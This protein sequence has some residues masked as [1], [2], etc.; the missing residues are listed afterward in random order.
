[1]DKVEL[2]TN[3]AQVLDE[4]SKSIAR[5]NMGLGSAS[6]KGVATTLS[7]SD[8]L[9]TANAVKSAIDEIK[10]NQIPMQNII[11]VNPSAVVDVTG[12]TYRTFKSAMAYI[13]SK[14]PTSENRWEIVLSSGTL[15]QTGTTYTLTYNSESI[16]LDENDVIILP[17]IY[18]VGNRTIINSYIFS[19]TFI[20]SVSYRDIPTSSVIENCII[21][22][23]DLSYSSSSGINA[24]SATRCTFQGLTNLTYRK[25][26]STYE[27]GI[28]TFD[29]FI[30]DCDLTNGSTSGVLN[31]MNAFFISVNSCFLGGTMPSCFV[32]DNTSYPLFKSIN[33]TLTGITLYGGELANCYIRSSSSDSF[34]YYSVFNQGCSYEITNC[35]FSDAKIL[36]NNVQSSSQVVFRH[37]TLCSNSFI[38]LRLS[39][40]RVLCQNC[41]FDGCHIWK[42]S[43]LGASIS[44][45]N[46]V[47]CAGYLNTLV[48]SSYDITDPLGNASSTYSLLSDEN[49][50]NMGAIYKNTISG[51]LATEVQEA[52]DELASTKVSKETGKILSSND[53]TDDEK[54]KLAGI[55]SGAEVNVQ[56]DWNATSGDALILNKPTLGTSSSKNY[57]ASIT[58]DTSTIPLTSAVYAALLLKQDALSVT[59]PLVL[60][61][62]TLSVSNATTTS[63]GVVEIGSNLSIADGVLSAPVATSSSNG[64]M[65]LYSS[66]GENTNG[67]MTQKSIFDALALKQNNITS[68]SS[69]LTITNSVISI[70]NATASSYGVVKI[71]TGL[72]VDS[73]GYL[74]STHI[75]Y[76]AGSGI[77]LDSSIISLLTASTTILGGVKVDGTSITISNGVISSIY[78]LPIAT[79]TLGGVKNGGNVVVSADGTMNY[80]L[81]TA[82]TSVLGGVKVGSNLS[83]AD[84]VLSG[85]PDTTYTVDTAKGLTLSGTLISINY[86]TKTSYGVVEVGDNISVSNGVISI[87]VATSSTLGLIKIG[88]GLDIVNG[89]VS[90]SIP[91]AS[92]S[93]LGLIKVGYTSSDKNYA[94]VLDSSSKAYVNVPWTDTTYTLP[95][96]SSTVLGGIKVGTNLSIDESG[97]LSAAT[98][99]Y[100]LPTASTTTLGGVK[101][102]GTTVLISSE[103]VISAVSSGGSVYQAGVGLTFNTST[104]PITINANYASATVFGVIKV[105]S[106]LSVT[107]GVLSASAP[108]VYT[109]GDGLS[110]TDG[111][112]ALNVASASTFGGTRIDGVSIV[113]SNGVISVGSATTSTIGGIIVGNGLN[114]SNSVLSVAQIVAGD[115]LG[116]VKNGGN[117]VIDSS[118]KMNY[119]LPTAS[120]SVLGGVKV[121]SNLSI[122]DGVLSASASNVYTAG[123]G[124]SLNDLEFSLAYATSS[125]IGGIIVGS[126]LSISDGILNYTLPTSS[127][128]TLGG[129]KVDGTSITISN[130]VISSVYTLPTA[131]TTLLGGVKIDG[132]SIT[133]SNGIISALTYTLP[134]ASTTTSGGIIVGSGLSISS[135]VLSVTALNATNPIN[136]NSSTN[137]LSLLYSTDYF[138]LN[139][140]NQLVGTNSFSSFVIVG[141][142][143]T[144]LRSTNA[145][146]SFS[147]IQGTGVTFTANDST[148]PK[149]LTIDLA[150]ATS[151]TIGGVKLYKETNAESW[152]TYPDDG[153]FTPSA[154]NY[155]VTNNSSYVS[156]SLT[157]GGSTTVT[158]IRNLIVANNSSMI[159]LGNGTTTYGTLA[160]YESTSTGSTDVLTQTGSTVSW[161]PDISVK[162]DYSATYQAKSIKIVTAIPDTVTANTLYVLMEA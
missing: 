10:I 146:T 2:L 123:L 127:T 108:N 58:N 70:A 134:A 81:P 96:A 128:T 67:T 143:T 27:C 12:A 141:S 43:S 63:F 161:V 87:P 136:Y 139:E 107:D 132:T 23:I 37:C 77:S 121:G 57:S 145:T 46:Y 104:S 8:D 13:L 110:L 33:S 135:G 54:S 112:F 15:D 156:Y 51:L 64:V 44:L 98:G 152:V 61:S 53:Y 71:G 91:T 85:T 133:I 19:R 29:S 103:G 137:T 130:G 9:I 157:S 35:S 131:S 52:L 80:T 4:D 86:S 120:T 30:I 76:V 95:V 39:E 32:K 7:D 90:T 14:S 38:F 11:Y 100:T 115:S 6:V 111:S 40:S 21:T 34:N 60:S 49:I 125:V 78:N 122:T 22:H 66:S 114:I 162:Y 154:M 42:M 144:T 160:P 153:A 151:S 93:D 82:S 129:V 99:S 73:N 59:Y 94:V 79:A 97:V 124:L 105:G 48:P 89:L 150:S 101:V 50:S 84:G 62:N 149:S 17:Y 83:I 69:C 142:T 65:F 74:N 106:N 31:D 109:A 18:I 148:S 56:S 155:F 126:T 119:T 158:N 138:G 113:T 117:V 16:T 45:I 118:G 68:G 36:I 72:S 102:D 92:S 24:I 3:T 140:S 55:A 26:S 116:F 1:M 88:T 25:S 147:F 5:S 20:T 41:V 47:S 75:D 28:F 159:T